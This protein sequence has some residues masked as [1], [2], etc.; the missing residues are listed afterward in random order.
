MEFNFRDLIVLKKREFYNKNLVINCSWD[1]NN[2]GELCVCVCVGRCVRI[3][4]KSKKDRNFLLSGKRFL[5]RVA[6]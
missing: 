5:H 6:V 1:L 4:E 3:I 2:E